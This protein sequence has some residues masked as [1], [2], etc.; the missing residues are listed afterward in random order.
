VLPARR[1][2]LQNVVELAGKVLM[3]EKEFHAASAESGGQRMI[4]W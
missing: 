1:E 2:V 3:Y 4:G